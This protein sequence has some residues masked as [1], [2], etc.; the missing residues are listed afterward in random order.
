MR[1]C[2]TRL[3]DGRKLGIVGVVDQLRGLRQVG[4]GSAPALG[5]ELELAVPVELVAEEV[6]ETDRPRPQ[7]LDEL[8]QSRLVHLE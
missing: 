7:A 8:R 3:A 4:H 2:R 6:A 5:H 1:R